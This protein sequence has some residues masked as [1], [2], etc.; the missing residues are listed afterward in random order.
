MDAAAEPLGAAAAPGSPADADAP[1]LP[2]PCATAVPIA[3]MPLTPAAVAAAAAAAAEP[4]AAALTVVEDDATV[5]RVAFYNVGMQ[6]SALDSKKS[7][8][9]AKRC[10]ALAHDIAEGFRMHRL[11]LL[12][13]CE[14]GEH[15]ICLHGKNWAANRRTTCLI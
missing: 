8:R 2:P 1:P 12:C 14:L 7:D 13:L 15:E 9:A 10:R 4:G 5:L 6:Q 3:A 11:D